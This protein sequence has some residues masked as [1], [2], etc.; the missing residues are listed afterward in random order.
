[1]G[2]TL[3]FVFCGQFLRLL[4][5]LEYRVS[6]GTQLSPPLAQMV[7]VFSLSLLLPWGQEEVGS[8]IDSFHFQNVTLPSSL[9]PTALN[10]MLFNRT[11]I[12]ELLAL[13]HS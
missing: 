12:T 13:G 1:M 11:G 4:A 7:T 5:L 6:L 10:L 9:R 2:S 8:A 3:G